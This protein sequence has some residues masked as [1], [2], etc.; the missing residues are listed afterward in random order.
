MKTFR[1]NR[2]QRGFFDFGIGLGL[3]AIF[4]GTAVV[5]SSEESKETVIVE[6]QLQSEPAEI[7][8]EIAINQS[9]SK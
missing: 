3:L 1:L 5:A 2:K 4:G 8:E 6:Q 7:P 9:A